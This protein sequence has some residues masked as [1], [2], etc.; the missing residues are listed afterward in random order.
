MLAMILT[1]STHSLHVSIHI[2]LGETLLMQPALETATVAVK[3][4]VGQAASRWAI[5][6]RWFVGERVDVLK[7]KVGSERLSWILISG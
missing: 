3:L 5:D 7:N 4:S 6:Q 2:A 1:A